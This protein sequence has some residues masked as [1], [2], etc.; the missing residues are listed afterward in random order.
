[1][2]LECVAHPGEVTFERL[3][4]LTAS[5]A[6]VEVHTAM[7]P[8]ARYMRYLSATPRITTSMMEALSDV[9]GPRHVAWKATC[10]DR[11]VGVVRLH[12]DHDGALEL[13][14]EV[15]DDHTGL[16]IGSA[17]VAMAIDHAVSLGA[18]AIRVFV[19]PENARAIRLFKAR[20]ASFSFVAG[21]LEG[22]ISVTPTHPVA[23]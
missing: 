20:G 11:A 2:A 21:D 4:R 14:V 6:L 9:D 7:S 22:T 19:H 18:T 16:G 10:A 12:K 23:A 17:L 1:M 3:N 5:R 13:A 8:T 15:A